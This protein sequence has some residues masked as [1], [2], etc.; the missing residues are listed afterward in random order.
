[1]PRA[2]YRRVI[3]EDIIA[4]IRSG[5]L[6]P[7]EQLPAQRALAIEYGCSIEPVRRALEDLEHGGWTYTLQGKGS[8]V[9]DSPPIPPPE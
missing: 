2:P 1:M 9:A 3:A 5:V 6:Q 8:F 4:K 7:G